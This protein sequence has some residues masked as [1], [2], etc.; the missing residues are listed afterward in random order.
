MV[1]RELFQSLR[2]GVEFHLG[3]VQSAVFEQ[4]KES[5]EKQL[6]TIF[7]H[8]YSDQKVL[9][10]LTNSAITTGEIAVQRTV[11]AIKSLP[12][13]NDQ[14]ARSQ[15]NKSG[16]VAIGVLQRKHPKCNYCSKLVREDVAVRS[17]D[18]DSEMEL[19]IWHPA[20]WVANVIREALQEFRSTK[21]ALDKQARSANAILDA[22]EKFILQGKFA[23]SYS[24]GDK[25][26]R[27]RIQFDHWIQGLYMEWCKTTKVKEEY[28][29]T[30]FNYF[31][32]YA[33]QILEYLAKGSIPAKQTYVRLS[34]HLD[35][36]VADSVVKRM[37]RVPIKT[38]R[39][40]GLLYDPD[41]SVGT[42]PQYV[43]N[44]QSNS[45]TLE[46]E[47]P[48][49]A[50][51]KKALCATLNPEAFFPEKGGSTREAKKICMSCDVRLECLDYAMTHGERFGI[52]GGLSEREREQLAR[53]YEPLKIVKESTKPSTKNDPSTPHIFTIE[54]NSF[55]DCTI[56]G[57][58]YRETG[59]VILNMANTKDSERNRAIDFIS[60]MIFA[61]HG[62]IQTIAPN[63][64][65]ITAGNINV[66]GKTSSTLLGENEYEN[67]RAQLLA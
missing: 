29:I 55:A 28:R 53:S 3:S 19:D 35:E 42:I 67:I 62:S 37:L 33:E 39:Y 7:P 45:N 64:F 41:D 40:L 20:C 31:K 34:K 51:S 60:G 36:E 32:E 49:L 1:E 30:Y 27:D 17:L 9:K 52:W 2:A 8:E 61:Q 43:N 18:F 57:Q 4:A 56:I 14:S 38:L 48:E 5:A 15:L 21:G 50:W 65:L 44:L 58:K 59:A 47:D 22:N 46:E 66:S 26:I 11:D 54:L 25:T 10:R 16:Y 6:K 12:H 23:T 24:S 63:V 13:W